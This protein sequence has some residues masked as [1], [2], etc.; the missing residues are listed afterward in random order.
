MGVQSLRGA[1][2]DVVVQQDFL[3]EEEKIDFNVLAEQIFDQVLING[4]SGNGPTH[5][6]I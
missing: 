4:N 1:N 5:N 6:Y 3:K 2:F